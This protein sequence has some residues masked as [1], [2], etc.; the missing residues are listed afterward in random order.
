MLLL[1]TIET[2]EENLEKENEKKNECEPI[3]TAES[4]TINQNSTKAKEK[5]MSDLGQKLMKNEIQTEKQIKE[6]KN[7][8]ENYE[9]SCEVNLFFLQ[10]TN[11]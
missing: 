7:E 9:K 3:E 5:P 11:S 8:K 4:M 2:S 1:E 10:D 6:D